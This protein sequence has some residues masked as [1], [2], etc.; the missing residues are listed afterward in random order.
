[1]LREALYGVH[2]NRQEGLLPEGNS[3]PEPHV[4]GAVPWPDGVEG[5]AVCPPRDLVDEV[6]GA[7]AV[8]PQGEVGPVLL[9]GAH[10]YDHHGG[11]LVLQPVLEGRAGKLVEPELIQ[12]AILRQEHH[13]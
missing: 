5:Y 12:L 4:V 6:P 10:P 1:M 7:Q 13:R 3:P 9:Y 8:H 2:E 11:G